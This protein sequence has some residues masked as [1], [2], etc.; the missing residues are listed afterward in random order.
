M[1]KFRTWL[2]L[3]CLSMVNLSI[4]SVLLHWHDCPR[5]RSNPE[6]HEQCDVTCPQRYKAQQNRL[7]ISRDILYIHGITVTPKRAGWHLKSPASRVF[8]QPF[9]QSQIKKTSKLRVTDLCE[10]NSPLTGEFPAQ[11]ASNVENLSIWWRHQG[12]RVH[13]DL[14][15][16]LF[17]ISEWHSGTPYAFFF[18]SPPYI[19]TEK[20]RRSVEAQVC[21][22][23]L[24]DE[25]F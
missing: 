24:P 1:H 4:F 21:I 10:G 17:F 14:D 5:Q 20:G 9:V 3:F 12:T 7:Y 11:V 19:Y 25:Y 23:R 16:T 6:E 22:N 15:L 18:V 13:V 2:C 8:P